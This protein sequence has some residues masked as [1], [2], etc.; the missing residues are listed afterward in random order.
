MMAMINFVMKKTLKK[1]VGNKVIECHVKAEKYFSVTGDIYRD[2]KSDRTFEMG[3][4]IHNEMAKHFPQVRSLIPLHLSD[5]EG[6]PMHALANGH[7]WVSGC[8]DGKLGQ[9]YTPDQSQAECR[10]ILE[11]HFRI[12]EEETQEVIDL[13]IQGGKE[14]LSA[15]VQQRKI[16]W[17]V[18]AI[19]ALSTIAAL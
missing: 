18:E 1:L 2:V 17:K 6:V 14:A 19:A 15:W 9:K 8:V 3:G 12:T 10:K 16:V 5:L 13:T 11:N 4:C 7:Y